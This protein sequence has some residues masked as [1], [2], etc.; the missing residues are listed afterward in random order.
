MGAAETEAERLAGALLIALFHDA[1]QRTALMLS[2]E[3]AQAFTARDGKPR[4]YSDAPAGHILSAGDVRDHLAGRRTWAAA[5]SGR[6]GAALAGCRDYD[7]ADGAELAALALE[8]LTAAGIT[9]FAQVI[10]GRAHVWALYR[11]PA[12]APDIRAQLAALCPTGDG[13]IYPSRNN[14]RLPL[15]LHRWHGTRGELLLQDGRRFALDEAGQVVAALRAILALRRNSPPPPA[16]PEVP[17]KT[18]GTAAPSNPT[19]WA[20]LPDGAALMASARY[21]GARGL[22]ARRPQLAALALG[23]RIVL[24][25]VHGLRDSGSEQVA[26]LVANLLTTGRRSDDGNFVSG[27]G[28]PPLPE[29]RALALFWRETL[30]PDQPLGAYQADVDRLICQYIPASYNPEPTRIGATSAA[31][32]PPALEA[33]RHR[34][35]P[36]GALAEALDRLAALLAPG[37]LVTRAGLAQALGV[38]PRTIT[39]HL[40]ELRRAGRAE[41]VAEPRGLRVVRVETNSP[42]PSPAE[43]GNQGPIAAS[44]RGEPCRKNTPAP[45]PG[46]GR[47]PAESTWS[48][49][50]V[51]AAVDAIELAAQQVRQAKTTERLNRRTGELRQAKGRATAEDVAA[52]LP[53]MEPALFRLAWAERATWRGE[54]AKLRRLEPPELRRKFS[55][56]RSSLAL[57]KQE[58]PPWEELPEERRDRLVQFARPKA[59][60][61]AGALLLAQSRH[62]TARALQRKAKL[63]EKYNAALLELLLAEFRRR[64]LPAVERREPV[65]R[66]GK[67]PTLSAAQLAKI[68]AK[69]EVEREAEQRAA[70]DRLIG[71]ARAS[72]PSRPLVQ[73]SPKAD[74]PATDEGAEGGGVCSSHNDPTVQP[75]AGAELRAGLIARLRARQDGEI[76]ACAD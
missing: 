58:L 45:P 30:R 18:A 21:S 37:I 14:I 42:A 56:V 60:D 50:E 49:A 75:L 69:R 31:P 35:R 33:P 9:A 27:L 10:N 6:D 41:L 48:E 73:L 53:G 44:Q 12:P 24:P 3:R 23:R 66:R 40:A 46:P 16:P 72:S 15:G 74:R 29:V 5:L 67:A 11:R 22:F 1:P 26:V 51:L 55:A 65:G 47:A 70:V 63:R 25:T 52:L 59:N 13:E 54:R 68:E 38:T 64:D 20:N 32:T 57:A 28:A 36:A 76:A 4:K 34:G 17:Q 2:W 7:G 19:D 43:G 8:R 61:D 39:N 62:N 71:R